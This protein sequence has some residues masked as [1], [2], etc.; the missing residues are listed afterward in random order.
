M[1]AYMLDLD[2]FLFQFSHGPLTAARKRDIHSMLEIGRE[3]VSGI[4]EAN[5]TDDNILF[6]ILS[7]PAYA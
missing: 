1:L 5:N 3:G 7:V 2:C 4:I 6:D